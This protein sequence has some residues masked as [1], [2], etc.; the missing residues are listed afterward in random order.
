MGTFRAAGVCLIL[1]LG[2]MRAAVGH[3]DLTSAALETCKAVHVSSEPTPVERRGHVVMSFVLFLETQGR[4]NP[5]PEYTAPGSSC[6]AEHFIVG[7]TQVLMASAG[8]Y[9]D[10][11]T[12]HYKIAFKDGEEIRTV[13]V[14]YNA[15]VSSVYGGGH[16]FAVSETRGAS[17][18]F[19]EVYKTQPTHADLK[20]LVT[21]IVREKAKPLIAGEFRKDDW[22]FYITAYD[23]TRLTSGK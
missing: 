23:K 3:A 7:D 2:L 6:I 17:T 12:L 21:T 5:V 13:L 10:L 4:E 15:M 1:A 19:Y 11:Q 22:E 18:S 8:F 14:L 9:K 20:A 16:Y